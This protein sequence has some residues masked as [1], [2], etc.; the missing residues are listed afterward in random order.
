M[1][2]CNV[3]S[4]V[5]AQLKAE[6]DVLFASMGMSVSDAIRMFLQQSVNMGGLPFQPRAKIPNA[7]TQA[8]MDEF[9]NGGGERFE[10][11]EA[12]LH[13]LEN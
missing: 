2:N 7:E 11:L 12:L 13:D 8:A 4:R 9:E 10:T 5:N 1:A 6:A 3:Q